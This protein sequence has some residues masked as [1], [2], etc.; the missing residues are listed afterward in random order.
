MADVVVVG[1]GIAGL[2]IATRCARA[3]LETVVVTKKNLS[4]SSTNWA[5]GGIAA[6]LDPDDVEAHIADTIAA[7]GGLCDE[8]VVRFVVREASD[9]IKDLIESGVQFDKDGDE[10]DLAMEGGHS[11]RRILHTKD[12]TGAEIE[13]ALI[14][15]ARASANLELLE[16]HMAIDIIAQRLEW[17]KWDHTNYNPEI[18][19]M[20]AGLW[21]LKPNGEVE[22]ILAKN[23]VL[24]T[25]GAGQIYRDT[26]N[27][28]VA[29]GDGMAMAYRAGARIRDMEFVQFHPT[30][31][32]VPGERPFLIS[33]AVRGHGGVL[34]TKKNV[35][36]MIIASAGHF[37]TIKNP[38]EFSFMLKYDER[39]SLATRDIVARAIEQEM[40][41]NGEEFVDL[42]THHLDEKEIQRKFPTI[43]ARLDQ[44]G[45]EQGEEPLKL[46]QSSLPVA[47]A[48]HYFVGGVQVNTEGE[49]CP[50][51][52]FESAFLNLF[53]VGEVASTGL[54]GANRLA[55]N[56][57]L[58]AVVFSQRCVEQITHRMGSYTAPWFDP[59]KQLNRTDELVVAH[60][61]EWENLIEHGPLDEFRKSLQQQMT[62]N[63]GIVKQ[64]RR[65]CEALENIEQMQTEVGD[66]W[67]MSRPTQELI[68]L[69][70]MIQ[71]AILV[72]TSALYRD[73][74]NIGLHYRVDD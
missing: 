48:A 35:Q 34:L 30:A 21:V 17:E 42:Y 5:Q 59:G 63:V 44:L 67:E 12:A 65:L 23:V 64:R 47:P 45:E 2:F 15:E 73:E 62:E 72:V 66:I 6:A 18:V 68:E 38:E 57:L 58:E 29:T 61:L 22:T 16:S 33:E 3:G 71:V 28:L 52:P 7:G 13:R 26:T 37:S 40:Q 69:R 9:R 10:F 49:V 1:S 51:N 70:N 14:A 25:G 4:D 24:A 27:P 36:K 56:S 31:L 54:H 60:K 53:A 8:D 43:Q 41:N 39:G 55:S 50:A 46:G 74:D 32:K 11:S 19:K 20:A